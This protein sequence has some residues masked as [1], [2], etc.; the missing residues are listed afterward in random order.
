MNNIFLIHGSYGNPYKNWLP[1]LKKEL[2]I[3]V[4]S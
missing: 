1:W 4:K 2:S 3:G